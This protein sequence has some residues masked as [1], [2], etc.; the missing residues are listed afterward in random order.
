MLKQQKDISK[1]DSHYK[2]YY[3]D[4]IQKMKHELKEEIKQKKLV[5]I[6]RI[7]LILKNQIKKK[8]ILE[9]EVDILTWR[10]EY[11][12]AIFDNY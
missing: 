1:K 5:Q 10:K 6:K 2:N 8:K 7:N 3:K 12:E 9:T 4:T 11:F